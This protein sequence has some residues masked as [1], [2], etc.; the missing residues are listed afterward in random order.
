MDRLLALHRA[1]L[2]SGDRPLAA[3]LARILRADRELRERADLE[4]QELPRLA[5]RRSPA[6]EHVLRGV[7][8]RLRFYLR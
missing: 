7:L 8:G 1:A 4:L 6:G 2:R 3:A 5:P